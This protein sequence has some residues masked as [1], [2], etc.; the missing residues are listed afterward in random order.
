MDGSI[1]HAFVN[2]QNSRTVGRHDIWHN[3]I[4]H[5]DTWYNKKHAA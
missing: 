4:Q 5:N 2:K 3:D 1:S